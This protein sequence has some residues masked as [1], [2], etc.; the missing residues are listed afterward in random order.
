[1]QSFVNIL[2]VICRYVMDGVRSD[3]ITERNSD[4]S[5]E[6]ELLLFGK[7]IISR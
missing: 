4:S 1:M 5:G 6:L 2:H 3:A 7:G